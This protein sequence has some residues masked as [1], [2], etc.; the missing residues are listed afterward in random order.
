MPTILFEQTCWLSTSCLCISSMP[1]IL[2]VHDCILYILF[3]HTCW[4]SMYA[5]DLGCLD[6]SVAIVQV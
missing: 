6:H 5:L 3:V 2:F 1:T 4:L